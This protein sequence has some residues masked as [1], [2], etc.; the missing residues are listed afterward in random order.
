M[1]LLTLFK[2]ILTEAEYKITLKSGK[3]MTKELSDQDY[4]NMQKSMKTNPN[5][6]VAS[7]ELIGA[8]KKPV[9]V[10]S[11]P[12]VSEP[13]KSFSPVDDG[14][15]FSNSSE[16]LL[17]PSRIFSVLIDEFLKKT[18]IKDLIRMGVSPVNIAQIMELFLGM[19]MSRPFKN[20][21]DAWYKL[22]QMSKG[23]NVSK[24]M[25]DAAKKDMV[26]LQNTMKSISDPLFKVFRAVNKASETG[27]DSLMYNLSPK[28]I[29]VYVKYYTMDLMDKHF[30]IKKSQNY[31]SFLS[32]LD[33]LKKSN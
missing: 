28:D 10:S 21:D 30:N 4:A 9:D 26:E 25:V 15:D 31:R 24:N 1:K 18:S 16:Y 11:E 19:T 3:T 20:V 32:M 2:I 8:S 22:D 17:S 33:E 12:E 13:V 14:V 27:D 23:A 5:N 6:I 29:D 7:V